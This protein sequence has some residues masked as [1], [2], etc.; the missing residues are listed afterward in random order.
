MKGMWK[1]DRLHHTTI[2]FTRF[3]VAAGA[4]LFGAYGV[5]WI[6]GAIIGWVR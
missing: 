6:A 4:F 5:V 1:P 3:M 2:A